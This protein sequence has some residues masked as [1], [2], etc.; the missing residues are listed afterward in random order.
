MNFGKLFGIMLLALVALT[1]TAMAASDYAITKLEVNGEAPMG[2]LNVVPGD[3]ISIHV[4]VKGLSATERDVRVQAWLGGY[5]YS[6]IQADTGMFKVAKNVTYQK[7]LTLELPNDL[8]TSDN[9]YTL[10]VKIYDANDVVEKTYSLFI[11]EPRH[12]LQIQDVVLV[13]GTTL[14]AGEVMYA[15]VRVE[16]MGYKLE[17]DI[18]V[19]VSIPKLG[20]SAKTYIDELNSRNM[21]ENSQSSNTLFVRLPEDAATGDYEVNVKL[22]YDRGHTTVQETRMVHVNAVVTEE[23]ASASSL[24]SFEAVKSELTVGKEQVFQVLVANM[25]NATSVYAVE[26]VG[27]GA[28]ADV[29]VNPGVVSVSKN[30]TGEFLVKVTPKEEGSHQFTLRVMQGDA[31]V[32]EKNMTVSVAKES[33]LNG[34]SPVWL[35]AGIVLVVIVIFVIVS[36]LQGE[37]VSKEDVEA[38]QYYQSA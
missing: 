19:E 16:N 12:N 17:E 15:K 25:D 11:E 22:T 9:G 28:W 18:A 8:N 3:K 20:A 31:V 29:A 37:K 10:H 36:Q 6:L 32:Q 14:N 26:A 34:I 13:P 1:G 27:A 4:N 38:G 21:D 24:V 33:K 30:S 7:Y 2:S 35:V 5:E 23:K